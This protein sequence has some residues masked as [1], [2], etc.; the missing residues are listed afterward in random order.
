MPRARTRRRGG[1]R[2]CQR[3]SG[4]VAAAARLLAVGKRMERTRASMPC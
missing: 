1:V 3:S 2:V 4:L